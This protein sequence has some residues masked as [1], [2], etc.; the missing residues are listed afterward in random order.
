MLLRIK[1][2]KNPMWKVHF[3][4]TLDDSKEESSST[5]SNSGIA[6]LDI[7]ITDIELW[8]NLKDKKE[9]FVENLTTDTWVY[10]YK[11]NK[12]S[13]SGN[14]VSI[15]YSEKKSLSKA[16]YREKIIENFI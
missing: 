6:T 14:T 16:E 5:I 3:S 11:I 2:Y 13:I 8:N 1:E 12:I 9:L 10:Y 15:H 4:F 7:N